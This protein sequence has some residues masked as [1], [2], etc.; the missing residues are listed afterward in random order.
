MVSVCHKSGRWEVGSCI[1]SVDF[2]M[3]DGD[4]L[5]TPMPG[6]VQLGQASSWSEFLAKRLSLI[7]TVG[8]ITLPYDSGSQLLQ[9][10]STIKRSTDRPSSLDQQYLWGPIT[11]QVVV[12]VQQPTDIFAL[13]LGTPD[14]V[15]GHTK[16]RCSMSLGD[17]A[18]IS[19]VVPLL[20]LWEGKGLAEETW[21]EPAS[22]QEY[23]QQRMSSAP[24]PA[25]CWPNISSGEVWE[26]D[27]LL[28]QTCLL[29]AMKHHTLWK[30]YPRKGHCL[31]SHVQTVRHVQ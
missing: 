9:L 12:P 28:P 3:E 22:C 16:R 29:Q 15:A 25:G 5:T 30:G 13:V 1:S 4:F 14:G 31:L 18:I 7:K 8:S 10:H 6:T 11:L 27:S 23:S 26:G 17:F 20:L 2:N 24:F 21:H 19:P